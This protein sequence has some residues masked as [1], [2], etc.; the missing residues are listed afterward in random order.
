MTSLTLTSL[1]DE[2]VVRIRVTTFAG[3]TSEHVSVGG[4]L[5]K[6]VATPFQEMLAEAQIAWSDV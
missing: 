6:G 4:V 5:N 2:E 1:Q 3:D